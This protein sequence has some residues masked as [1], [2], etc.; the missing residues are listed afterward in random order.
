MLQVPRR[1]ASGAALAAFLALPLLSGCSDIEELLGLDDD[2]GNPNQV[3]LNSTFQSW[4]FGSPVRVNQNWIVY[5]ASEA[6]T[7][8][9]GRDYNGDGD[10]QDAVAGVVSIGA[11]IGYLLPVAIQDI[12][13]TETDV[14]MVVDEDDDSR[15]WNG[16]GQRDDIVLVHWAGGGSNF[17]TVVNAA[18][19][20]NLVPVGDRLYFPDFTPPIVAPDTTLSFVSRSSPLTP[21]RVQNS[22][23]LNTLSPTILAG[24][25]DLLFLLLNEGVEGRDLNGDGDFNDPAVLALLDGT[26]PASTIQNVGLAVP[27]Q[28]TPVRALSTGSSDWLVAFLVDETG[29]G[30]NLNQAALFPAGWQPTQCA[31]AGDNDLADNVLHFLSYAAFVQDPVVNAPINTG[32]V[33]TDRVFCLPGPPGSPGFVGTISLESDEGGCSLNFQ[34]GNGNDA[35]QNDRILRWVEA[36]SP[37]LPFTNAQALVA[38]AP[39]PGG[40][41]GVAVLGGRFVTVV[42]EAAD[43]RNWDQN[44]ANRFLVAWLDPSQ[45]A[46]ARWTF[47]HSA[48]GSGY[49]GADW[50][51]ETPN[52]D[53]VL[54]GVQEIVAG[55][56]LNVGDPD[57]SDTVP[58][59]ARFDPFFPDDLDFPGPPV[60]TTVGNS[61]MVAGR[62]GRVVYQVEE[63]DDRKDWNGD[64]DTSDTVLVRTLINSP[65]STSFV[66]T[67]ADDDGNGPVMHVVQVVTGDGGVGFAAIEAPANTD[68]NFDGDRS[69]FVIR[70]VSL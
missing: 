52:R 62:T 61:M 33:G 2:D 11:G 12:V 70:W 16:D 41:F 63:S 44:P 32:L 13:A 6:T 49:V 34:S 5:M 39:V 17:V 27:G 7:G 18:T 58:A 67:I 31:G 57:L 20:A 36:Q 15:D 59:F 8:P 40:G 35:D 21:R 55:L 26:D 43:S 38:Q 47:D 37:V 4:V 56:S 29:E 23:V 24:D 25:E 3:F 50:L 66:I 69:D 14:Y 22:D 42:D 45:G 64:G 51:G 53:R 60:A 46:M 68:F 30:T 1:R 10:V 28:A 48:A 9:A 65:G 54:V 19:A